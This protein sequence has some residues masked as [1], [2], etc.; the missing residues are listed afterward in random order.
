MPS[1]V[2]LPTMAFISRQTQLQKTQFSEHWRFLVWHCS[3]GIRSSRKEE[4][5]E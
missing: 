2:L 3:M 5:H 1:V 4:L